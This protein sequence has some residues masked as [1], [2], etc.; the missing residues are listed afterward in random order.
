MP[1]SLLRDK[2]VQPPFARQLCSSSVHQVISG[3][4]M[5]F[6]CLLV[7]SLGACSSRGGGPEAAAPPSP[8]VARRIASLPENPCDLLT[9]GEVSVATGLAVRRAHRVPDIDE[10]VQAGKEGRPARTNT[11]CSY[12]VRGDIVAITITVPP[13]SDRNATAYMSARDA[14][15]RQ[16]PGSAR[17]VSG[18]GEDAWLAG[19]STLHVLAGKDAQ[20]IVATRMAQ[21]KSPEVLVAVA[22]AVVERLNR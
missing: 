11:I 14:Y 16:Y 13:V 8:A 19:G 10:I 17:A 12:D 9:R 4:C 1:N 7:H 6:A 18:V 3:R 2:L 5:I 22:R 15:L 21:P 20:F